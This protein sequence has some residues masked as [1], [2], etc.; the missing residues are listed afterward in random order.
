MEPAIK[1]AHKTALAPK[2]QT[3]FNDLDLNVD[4]NISFDDEGNPTALM[5]R[6]SLIPY[7]TGPMI[8]PMKEGSAFLGFARAARRHDRSRTKLEHG[9]CQSGKEC[10]S[11]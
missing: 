8:F 3:C 10:V 7:A 9:L 4:I 2:R 1:P 6:P 11:G 5:N